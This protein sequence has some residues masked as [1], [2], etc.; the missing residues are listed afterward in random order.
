MNLD[1]LTKI[2][3]RKKPDSHIPI[4]QNVMNRRQFIRG[5]LAAVTVGCAGS[6]CLNEEV[7]N[8]EKIPLAHFFDHFDMRDIQPMA[9][10]D[11]QKY[12][13]FLPMSSDQAL[14]KIALRSKELAGIDLDFSLL[15]DT[16]YEDGADSIPHWIL[17]KNGYDIFYNSSKVLILQHPLNYINQGLIQ[18]CL[19]W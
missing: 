17:K 16:L 8:V 19:I 2:F 12:P 14:G 5:S 7:E 3:H 10:E 4:Q 9:P 11:R 1:R 18:T 6:G 15:I 13:E